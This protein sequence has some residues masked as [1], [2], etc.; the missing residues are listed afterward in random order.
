M[1]LQEFY[2]GKA[3][4][5]YEYFG[6]HPEEGGY[7]FRTYAPLA[8]GVTVVGDF[9][10]WKEVPMTQ[11]Y[12][13]GIW[14]MQS[15]YARPGHLYKYCIYGAN[16]R[17]E[18]CDP[19]G[20]G[21]ELRPGACSIVR[22][23]AEYRF[24]DEKWMTGRS[25]RYHEPLNIYE[26][27]LGSWKKP[28]AHQDRPSENAEKEEEPE[29]TFC[30][31]NGIAGDLISY[32]QEHHYNYVEFLPISEHPFDGSWGYQNTGFFAPTARYGKAG[33]LMELIDR[34]HRAGIG[35]IMDFVPV[36][37]A[38][39]AYGLKEFD[40]TALYEYPNKDVGESE[41]GS[42]NFNHC[43]FSMIS[44]NKSRG[45]RLWHGSRG[46]N[47]THKYITCLSDLR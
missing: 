28:A 2:T 21:M 22:N 8:G 26:L 19:Y 43:L 12:Q 34:L 13:S 20:F 36:H 18:H 37:F 3:F 17:Q 27:H 4:D 41:W 45:E 1:D 35:A 42:C 44:S 46:L 5:A 9:T 23:L 31:Y 11:Q 10:D 30:T 6:A 39:D 15:D 38:V 47:Y 32:L 7:V 14:S 16:G 33:Q 24:T 29:P 25:R 40:G